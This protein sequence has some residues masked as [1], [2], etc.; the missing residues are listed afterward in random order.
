MASRRKSTTPCMVPPRETIDSDQDMEDAADIAEEEEASNGAA[1]ASAE[2]CGLFDEK[3]EDLEARQVSDHYMDSNSAEGGYECKYC[4]F[5]TAEL[6]LFTVHVDTEHPDIVLNSSYVCMECDFHT[7]RYDALLEHNARHHPGEDNFTRTMVKRNNQTIFQQTVNDLTFDGSFVKMEDD[8]AEETARKSIALS[9]TPIMRIRSRTEAKKFAGSHKIAAASIDDVIKVESDDEDYEN[10]EPPT[11]SPAPIAAATTPRFVAVSTAIQVQP[12]QQSIVVSSPNLLQ[13]KSSSTSGGATVLPPGTLAQ[14]LSALQNQQNSSQSQTQLL[15]PLSS[16]PTYNTAMD[17]NVLL[18]SAYNRFP[19]PSVSEIMGL[20]SQTKFSEEQIK[21]WFSAQRLKHGVSWT[22]EEVEEAR[23]KKFNGTVQAVPQ[24]ITVIPANIATATNGLQSIFQ[25]CQIVGQP[26]LVLTQVTGNGSGL[27]VASPITLTVAGVPSNQAKAAEPSTSESK[28]QM[29]AS[30]DRTPLSPDPHATKPKKSKEQ[31]AELKASYGRRQFAT[32]AEISRLMRVTNLT[33]RAIKKWFSDTRYNQRNSKDHHGVMLSET[34]SGVAASGGGVGKNSSSNNNDGGSYTTIIIDSSDDASDCS[35]TS[36]NTPGASSSFSDPRVKFRHAF[37]D[38]TPQK[39]KEKTPDQLLVL[40]A[41]FQTS[42]TPSDEELS[43]LRA[44]TKLTRREVDAW[45][46]E[47]RKTAE[48]D[49]ENMKPSSSVLE[50]QTTP[51]V[52]RKILKKTPEQLHILKMA[53]VRTQWPTSEEYDKMAEDSGLPRTYIVNWFGDTRYACKNS[54]LKWYYLYQSGKV[55]EALNGGA[56][57]PKKSR[58]R[59]RGWSRRTRRPYPCK[60]SPQG[61]ATGIKVKTGKEFLKEHYLKHR[62][63]SEKDLDELVSKSSMSYEQ[64]RDWFAETARRV[65]EGKEPFSEDE[66]EGQEHEEDEE[67]EEAVVEEEEEE[68]ADSEGEME[69]KEQG[70]EATDDD[71]EEEEEEEVEEEEV[72]DEVVDDDDDDEEVDEEEEEKTLRIDRLCPQKT[73]RIDRLCPQKT[74]RIDRLCPQKTLHIDRLCP[75][76]TLRIDRLCPQKTLRI[77]R[78]C[79]QKTLRIDR[80]C[81]QKT[82]RTDRLCTQKTLRIDRLCPQKTLRIDRL[83][84][85]KTLRIDRLCPQKTLRTDRL[86]TQKTLRIDRLC[87][88]KTLRIDRLCTQKTLHIDRLCPQKTLCTDRLCPQKTLR[89]DRLCTQKTLHIDRLCPQ[90]TLRIDRLCP[91][92]T[93]R[94]DRLCTQKT[95]HIDRLCP[96]KTLRIDRLCPQKTLRIDRL[97]PQKTLRIDRLCPQKT[98]RIDRLCPQKTLRIDRLCPLKTLRIDRL[99]PQKTLRID[100]LCPQKTLRIDR[101]CPQKT[102][103]IDRLCPQKTLRIDRLCTQKTLRIDRLC[104]QKTLRID[105]LCPQKTLRIDRL[106]PQ[107]TL[108]IDLLCPQKT[109]RIDRLCP[110]KTLRIDRPCPLKTLRIDRPCPQKTLRIDRLCP[111]KTLRTDRLCP[112]KT[113]C[114]DLL[115]PQ[116]T[117]R[118]DRLCPQK[119]LRID[120]LCPQK[121]L[122]IDR[123]CPQ[124]TLRIDRLCPQ[125]TLRIDRLCPQKTLHIARL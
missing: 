82:L 102:L 23:R 103:C 29:S 83:C 2:V 99:C 74:L 31:L 28:T 105:R 39:F 104:P 116:K 30:L 123:L 72:D 25:T 88:Q 26:G 17:N 50:R 16:I 121:T 63:L 100:R 38:F 7:K 11:L 51:L 32:E 27:P 24:T 98:L 36:A 110:Q 6:N 35:P 65:E 62:A 112:Q 73:L 92:K 55:D 5:Q 75:Q 118:I 45:F 84:P 106:C 18:V 108:R 67:E 48:V 77:D 13:F 61:P 8:E 1:S 41:S 114:I 64:V 9:K 76:K 37:P 86:C 60:R 10:K 69:V 115:C 57:T 124:K 78:L 68:H 14:V 3:G 97:C 113:L 58:K 44:E 66:G 87:P 49:G 56:K 42:D 43:R 109:L 53:F 96:Q 46:T 20:S 89:T 91:Q 71:H 101:L 107:K 120:R 59:F 15:I 119:T 79:P 22:P 95:L 34:S 4:S 85:Q 54:N 40:E 125:K 80:L 94:T 111:Q 117:L 70:E 19:Y 21:V 12:V 90:K 81:P 52:G 122:R 33:K 47:R 93:L